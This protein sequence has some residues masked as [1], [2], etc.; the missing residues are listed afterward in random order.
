MKTIY[1]GG[2]CFWCTE[3]VFKTLRGVQEVIPGYMGGTV[4]NPTYEAVCSDTTGHVEVV[5][6][7]YDETVITTDDILDIFFATH[8]PTTPN[9]QG[10]DVGSQY[11]SVIFYTHDQEPHARG[12][13]REDGSHDIQGSIQRSISRAQQSVGE[14]APIVTEVVSATEFYPAE[15][16]HYNYYAQHSDA[17]YCQIVISPKLEKLQKKFFDKLL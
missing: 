17:P 12:G 16:Y 10:N 7:Y 8:D 13:D 15:E 14:D 4:P 11:R 9:R 1:L 5:K 6:V 3:A 2:G